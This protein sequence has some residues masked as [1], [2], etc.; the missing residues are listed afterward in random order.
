MQAYKP[1]FSLT[2]TLSRQILV[3]RQT[4]RNKNMLARWVAPLAVRYRAAFLSRRACHKPDNMANM[5]KMFMTEK[6]NR[7]IC[8]STQP[9][10]P[11]VY[12]SF[13]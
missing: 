4:I 1:S 8:I 5:A 10:F 7:K 2:F 11:S 9:A 13:A 6:T 3:V 12:S